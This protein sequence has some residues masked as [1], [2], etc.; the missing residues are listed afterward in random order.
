MVGMQFANHAK[1][2][3]AEIA[4]LVELVGFC[5]PSQHELSHRAGHLQQYEVIF[6]GKSSHSGHLNITRL[7]A[8]I[9]DRF[10]NL[11]RVEAFGFRWQ[12][13][14]LSALKIYLHVTDAFQ[15]PQGLFG[16]VGSKRSNHPV[17]AHCGLFDLGGQRRRR[18][19]PEYTQK[20]RRKDC[21]A[22]LA[23]HYC[24]LATTC[25]LMMRLLAASLT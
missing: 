2:A 15:A 16:P 7:E 5:T 10:G 18:R 1:P 17:Y 21:A 3:L 9:L 8:G 14:R 12:Y 13:G 25:N 4:S 6:A 24:L 11:C 19:E 23:V 22:N 20:R